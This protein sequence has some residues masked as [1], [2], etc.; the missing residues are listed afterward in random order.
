[1]RPTDRQKNA[2]NKTEPAMLQLNC[3]LRLASTALICGRILDGK[4]PGWLLPGRHIDVA[5]VHTRRHRMSTQADPD[6]ALRDIPGLAIR[7]PNGLDDIR[8]SIAFSGRNWSG[9]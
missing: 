9:M 5:L 6:I 4:R 1:V 7:V 3:G 2:Q 8:R